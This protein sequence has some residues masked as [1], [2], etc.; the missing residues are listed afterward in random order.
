MLNLTTW[1]MTKQKKQSKIDKI[2]E[3]IANL[4]FAHQFSDEPKD[5]LDLIEKEQ[6]KLRDERR[7]QDTIRQGRREEHNEN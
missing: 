2:Q 7:N 4:K 5:F 3:K 6:D 1:N